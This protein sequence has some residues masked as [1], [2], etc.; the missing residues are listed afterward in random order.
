VSYVFAE[1]VPIGQVFTPLAQ[2]AGLLDFL[3]DSSSPTGLKQS[4]GKFTRAT[5]RSAKGF[6][7]H[8]WLLRDETVHQDNLYVILN[9]GLSMDSF[10]EQIKTINAELAGNVVKLNPEPYHIQVVAVDF[11]RELYGDVSRVYCSDEEPNKVVIV[12]N[13]AAPAVREEFYSG[14]RNALKP[15]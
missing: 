15:I 2:C 1:V 10:I 3:H 11:L 13:N 5:V 7:I 8:T 12:F 9:L 4:G 14:N 6:D